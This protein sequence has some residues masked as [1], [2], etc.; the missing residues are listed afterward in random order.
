M[1]ASPIQAAYLP[2]AES[3]QAGGFSDPKAGWT[4]GQVGAH[5]ALSN[6]IFSELADRLHEGEDVSFDNW[7]T[8]DGAGLLAYAKQRGDLA[9]LA[10]AIR[11]SA[12]QLAQAYENL[13]EEERARP[14]PVTIWHEG[15]VVQDEPMPLGELI[16]GHGDYHLAMHIE[17]LQALRTS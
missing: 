8:Q 14:I 15:Q 1:N 3:L 9:G 4:A 5:V 7:P 10:E 11:T 6:E 16:I 17:Q 12:A 2:F 13:T